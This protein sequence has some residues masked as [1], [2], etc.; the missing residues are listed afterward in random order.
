[1]GGEHLRCI[2]IW[3][4]ALKKHAFCTDENG[5]GDGWAYIP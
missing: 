2:Y 4:L 1:M 3:V 5:P